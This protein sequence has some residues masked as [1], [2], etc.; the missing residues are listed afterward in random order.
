[1]KAIGM[2]EIRGLVPAIEAID[3]M[4]KAADVEFLTWEKKL[5]GWLVTV[6]VQGEVSAVEAAVDTAVAYAINK[7]AASAVIPNPHP[8]IMNQIN[9]SIEKNNLR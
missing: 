8:E 5:G 1:M 2:I 3:R 4:T 9:I 7:V 6:M